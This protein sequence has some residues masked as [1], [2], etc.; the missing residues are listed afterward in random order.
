[1][2]GELTSDN[3]RLKES[4]RTYEWVMS[5]IWMSLSHMWMSHVTHM[6]KWCHSPAN[7]RISL[8]F[9]L[10]FSLSLFL[11]FSLSQLSSDKT[12]PKES[13]R[14]HNESRNPMNESCHTYEWVMSLTSRC[15]ES[16][17][18]TRPIVL[19]HILPMKLWCIMSH[20]QISHATHMTESSRFWHFLQKSR[21]KETIFCKRDL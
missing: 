13:C 10:S 14:P 7:A 20:M 9:S 6:N 4:C 2:R 8:F 5:H 19:R 16:F 18:V 17:L 1:M 11:S 3:P 12:R 21:I 15:E